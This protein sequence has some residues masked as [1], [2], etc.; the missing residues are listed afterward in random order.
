MLSQILG[1]V[2]LKWPR[3]TVQKTKQKSTKNMKLST[4][5]GRFWSL[6]NQSFQMSET[7]FN[8]FSFW[9]WSQDNWRSRNMDKLLLNLFDAFL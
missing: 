4:L 3:K 2:A 9:F 7:T 8:G 5:F 6:N 1:K